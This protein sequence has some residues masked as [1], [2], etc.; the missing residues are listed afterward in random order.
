MSICIPPGGVQSLRAVSVLALMY[1]G[2][3]WQQSQGRNGSGGSDGDA[4]DRQRWDP[5]LSPP[6]IHMYCS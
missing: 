4:S 1:S 5:L 2:E 6:S 3:V